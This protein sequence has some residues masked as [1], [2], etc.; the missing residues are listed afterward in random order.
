MIIIAEIG[1]ILTVSIALVFGLIWAFGRR[2][3]L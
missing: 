3:E 1:M 2:I